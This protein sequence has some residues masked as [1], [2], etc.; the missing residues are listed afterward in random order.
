MCKLLKKVIDKGFTIILFKNFS[1]FVSFFRLARVL[2]RLYVHFINIYIV[3]TFFIESAIFVYH[4]RFLL[5]E[6]MPLKI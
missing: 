2:L 3:K 5:F 4:R 1:V 6:M